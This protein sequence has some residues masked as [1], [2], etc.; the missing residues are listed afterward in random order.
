MLKQMRAG[1]KSA[2]AWLFVALLVPAFAL[3]GVP[4]LREF[5]QRPPMRVGDMAI[6]ARALQAEYARAFE[7]R[8]EEAGGKYTPENAR[9]DGLGERVADQVATRAVLELEARRLGLVMPDRLVENYLK[10]N[11]AFKNPS[12]GK[13]DDLV[14]QNILR[15]NNLSVREFEEIIKKDLLRGQLISS[16]SAGA[17]APAEFAEALILRETE[18]RRIGYLTVTEDLA[19][20]AAAATD[21]AVRAYYD[22]HAAEFRTPEYRTFTAVILRPS[23]YSEGLAPPEDELRQTY[24]KNRAR[25]YEEPEK[26]TL[27]QLVYDTEDAAKAAVA[28]LGSG[29]PFEAL[30]RER[31]LS[32]A[33]ATFTEIT[34]KDV[35]DPAVGG[36][37]FANG[38]KAG[39][40]VG[41]VKGMFGWTVA[42]IAAVTA[43]KTVPFEEA[44]TA[45]VDQYVSQAT[46]KRLYETIEKLE[47]E[48]DTG[49]PLAEAAKSVGVIAKTYGPVDSY[50]FA[51]GGAI[52]ADV[53]GEAL[54]EAFQIAEGEESSA[55]EMDG[56]GYFIV[57]VDDVRPPAAIPFEEVRDEAT[58]KWRAEERRAR[59]AAKVAEISKALEGGEKLAD[60][61]GRLNRA[62]LERIVGRNEND[63][64]FS[65][66]LLDRIF[67]ADLGRAVSGPAGA[68]GA[69]TIA[70]IR[71]IGFRR[72]AVSAPEETSFKQFLGYQLNQEMVEAYLASLRKDYGVKVDRDRLA[73]IFN[74]SQ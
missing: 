37:T 63:S 43:P 69:V 17:P 41:P 72:N 73:Q 7:R 53:P 71:E 18:Q 12:T 56:G 2:S 49:A 19:G 33:A 29:K 40:V 30:A 23:D 62:A 74:E 64:A 50:S 24:E 26:R 22:A 5:V 70:E 47:E 35:L 34:R 20:P 9:A 27:Y 54:A 45:L 10:T 57:Q 15:T 51:P 52:L 32:L 6:P 60:I 68:G 21:E 25:L 28:S 36:A 67:S 38:L 58:Q 3:W 48:R 65:A 31:G 55:K 8:R 16:L 44:R 46:R 13:F 42:Q 4:E 1:L 14:L 59:I 11:E 39:D 61:A 66:E